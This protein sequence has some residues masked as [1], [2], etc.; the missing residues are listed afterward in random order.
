M[1][2]GEGLNERCL[3]SAVKKVGIIDEA[4]RKGMAFLCADVGILQIVE[5]RRERFLRGIVVLLVRC[6]VGPGPEQLDGPA[7]MLHQSH[8]GRACPR[9]ERQA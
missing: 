9:R 7:M 3:A 2:R 5:E 6:I 8:R 1:E 4:A